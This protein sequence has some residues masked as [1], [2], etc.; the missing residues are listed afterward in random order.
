MMSDHEK[1]IEEAAKAIQVETWEPSCR[2]AAE[3]A[4]RVFEKAHTTTPPDGWFYMGSHV[5]APWLNLEFSEEMD[6]TGLPLWE[7]PV[8]H[9]PTDDEREALESALYEE[10]FSGSGEEIGTHETVIFVEH[11]PDIVARLGFRRSE[12][13]EP[14]T[15]Q[16]CLGTCENGRHCCE[17]CGHPEPS[18]LPTFF[19]PKPGSTTNRLVSEPQR[20]LSDA[21]LLA[22]G[23]REGVD[24]VD[25]QPGPWGAGMV[26]GRAEAARRAAA[27]RAAGGVR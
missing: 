23:F 14:S 9:T 10:G 12:V 24:F 25:D 18:V 3:A 21:Q 17:N 6:E 8:Q 27:A 2:A 20:E 16:S 5:G 19:A 7:R 15:C 26:A 1:L 22:Q 11:V 4:F 13:S